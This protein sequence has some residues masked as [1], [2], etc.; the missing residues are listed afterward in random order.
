MSRNAQISPA[1]IFKMQS[2]SLGYLHMN[3]NRES[4][5]SISNRSLQFF[6]FCYVFVA[7][8]NCKTVFCWKHLR[9]LKPQTAAPGGKHL[10]MVQMLINAMPAAS[11]LT[12]CFLALRLEMKYCNSCYS[13]LK[14][15]IFPEDWWLEDEVSF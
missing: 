6:L 14:T 1:N 11:S 3:P 4:V 15:N 9:Q 2:V 7:F 8:P 13:P 5:I 12:I 10:S